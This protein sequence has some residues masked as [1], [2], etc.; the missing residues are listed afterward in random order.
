MKSAKYLVVLALTQS[1]LASAATV[2]SLPS[3]EQTEEIIITGRTLY[4]RMLS[5]EVRAYDI[6]NRFND[7]KRFM[8]S[9]SQYQPTGRIV[10]KQVC[11]PAFEIEALRTQAQD[12][13]ESLRHLIIPGGLPDGSV[14]PTHAPAEAMIA[15]QM[16]AYRA[17]LKQVAEQHP[18]FMQ[19]IID[20]AELRQ[21]YEQG[22]A[23]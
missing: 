11:S 21:Q 12:F 22:G 1:L 23:E 14:M 7:E 8:I 9:C 2:Q 18:E 3:S 10:A 6:F 15:G 5:A 17:K 19:A 4:E 13:H 20:F 16:T